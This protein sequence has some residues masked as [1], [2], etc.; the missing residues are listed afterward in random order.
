MLNIS[1]GL[2]N[3]IVKTASGSI[4]FLLEIEIDLVLANVTN[5]TGIRGRLLAIRE[6]ERVIAAILPHTKEPQTSHA[7]DNIVLSSVYIDIAANYAEFRDAKAAKD[8]LDRSSR[9]L[10]CMGRETVF[11]YLYAA[12]CNQA[13]YVATLEGNFDKALQLIRRSIDLVGKASP[14]AYVYQLHLAGILVQLTFTE[15]ADNVLREII[16]NSQQNNGMNDF[17]AEATLF[18]GVLSLYHKDHGRAK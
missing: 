12:H 18:L 15:E 4:G 17:A 3:G 10:E 6:R 16:R 2:V 14:L 11:P 9:L 8:V 7:L 13:A 5:T 1:L